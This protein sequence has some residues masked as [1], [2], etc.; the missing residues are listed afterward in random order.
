MRTGIFKLTEE[1]RPAL[2]AHLLRLNADDRQMRF[3]SPMSDSSLQSFVARCPVE[4]TYGYFSDGLLVA[5]TMLM[6]EDDRTVEF[7]VTVD[8]DQRGHGLAKMLL[9]HGLGTQEAEH[10]EQMVIHHLLENRA[11]AAVHKAMPSRRHSS[12]GEVA[13]FIDLGRV[14]DEQL[15]AFGAVCGAEV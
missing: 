7:A 9:E 4:M 10:A 5:T 3:F 1:D 12:G 2:V 11:M 14:R 13:V 15:Q 6:P 8:A